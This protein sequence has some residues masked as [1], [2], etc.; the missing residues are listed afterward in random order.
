M[1]YV[2][3]ENHKYYKMFKGKQ[4]SYK[5]PNKKNTQLI[6]SPCTACTEIQKP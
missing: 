4:L 1:L 2:E 5:L 3:M 6:I